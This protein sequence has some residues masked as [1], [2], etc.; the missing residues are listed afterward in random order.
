MLQRSQH[1]E[2]KHSEGPNVTC[3]I[4]TFLRLLL[5]MEFLSCFLLNIYKQSDFLFE[6]E[7]A[8]PL[9]LCF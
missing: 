4:I 2:N 8:C 3:M 1:K 9:Y 6:M 5:A 7:N